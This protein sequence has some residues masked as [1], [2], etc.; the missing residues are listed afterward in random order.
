[1]EQVACTGN[2]INAYKIVIG[3]SEERKILGRFRNIRN[4]RIKINLIRINKEAVDWI[5]LAEN[6]NIC[7]EKLVINCRYKQ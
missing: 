4:N 2:I 1:M 6:R 7:G 5:H 3:H